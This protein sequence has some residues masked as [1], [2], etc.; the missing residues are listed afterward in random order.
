MLGA[1]MKRLSIPNLGTPGLLGLTGRTRS[2]QEDLEKQL[3]GNPGVGLG[4]RPRGVAIWQQEA[5]TG[6]RQIFFWSPQ[7]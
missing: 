1:P 2:R 7:P 5:S 3:G 4:L 6:S